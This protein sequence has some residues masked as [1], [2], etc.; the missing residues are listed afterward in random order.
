MLQGYHLGH[1]VSNHSG[2]QMGLLMNG[3]RSHH[4]GNPK[5]ARGSELGTRGED[6]MG[7]LIG[8]NNPEERVLD[9]HEQD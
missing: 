2:A 9:A 7:T 5:G 3:R 8:H 1:L 6:S 4:S